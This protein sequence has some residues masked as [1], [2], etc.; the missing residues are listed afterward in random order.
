MKLDVIRRRIL[1]A[2]ALSP[3]LM[4][5]SGW[6]ASPGVRDD[7]IIIGSF[8][9]LQSGLAAGAVQLRDGADAWF[10][11]TNDQGGIHGRKIE[12]RVENDSYN[13]Q[14]TVAVLR[15][16]IDR[17]GVFAVVSTLGTATNLA[18]LPFLAQR[19]VPLVNPAGG[20][21]QLNAPTDPNV[22]GLLPVGQV[23]G[24]AMVD[25]AVDTMGAKRV[26]ILFQN[27]PFGKDP[28]DGAVE[29]LQARGME[30]VAE[31]SYVPSDVDLS[32]QAVA[33]REANP[34]VVLLM[35]ITKPGAQFVREAQRLGWSPQFL[36]QNTMGDPIT[37]D[38]A[39]DALE[40]VRVILFT[41]IETMDTPA[42]KEAN[43]VVRKYHPQTAPG[44]WTYLGIAGAKVFVEGAMRA[45]PDLTRE[46][47]MQALY[48]LGNYEPGVVPPLNWDEEN[49]GGPT[50]F[51]FAQWQGGKLH[52][53][54]GW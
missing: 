1:A 43:E 3:A 35:C 48:S 53:L 32:A 16:L 20:H 5:K 21:A 54:E 13:P 44:Y 39:G 26:A 18:A 33:L 51:G 12:W 29:E 7:R 14:Q 11:H 27:D 47:F 19:N 34:D 52:T 4:V 40:G 50:T 46:S 41:A 38:L 2:T 42:V 10:K 15:K 23:I 36:A 6:A 24:K 25:Y 17:E 28:R 31:A 45:G 37:V 22:F 8:L 9:P 49:H 30:V